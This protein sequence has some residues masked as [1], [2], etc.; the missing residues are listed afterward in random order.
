MGCFETLQESQG[1]VIY[2]WWKVE[3]RSQIC[4]FCA[5]PC[6]ARTPWCSASWTRRSLCKCCLLEQY[7]LIAISQRAVSGTESATSFRLRGWLSIEGMG[8]VHWGTDVSWLMQF[9]F[10]LFFH[11]PKYVLS[12]K[13]AENLI[14]QN[15]WWWDLDLFSIY[16]KLYMWV[17]V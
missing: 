7:G 2:L 6:G 5:T 16:S 3:M 15:C 14:S 1:I 8:S 10:F 17:Q 4:S 11:G 9:T 13:S 12:H